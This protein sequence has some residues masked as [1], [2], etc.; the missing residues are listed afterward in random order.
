MTE[1]QTDLHVLIEQLTQKDKLIT[2]QK[3]RIE[4]LEHRLA[5]RMEQTVQDYSALRE[6]L[7]RMQNLV[8]Q[9]FLGLPASTGLTRAEL[10]EEFERQYGASLQSRLKQR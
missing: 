4:F 5:Q 7:D 2:A 3:T 9:I 6:R 8:C 10:Q 1:Q